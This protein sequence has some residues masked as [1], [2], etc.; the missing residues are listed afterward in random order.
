MFPRQWW[1]VGVRNWSGAG[2]RSVRCLLEKKCQH[3]GGPWLL[4]EFRGV[5][6]CEWTVKPTKGEPEPDAH[7][8]P[9]G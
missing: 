6:G 2:C 3:A 7:V 9:G 1:G 4:L 5:P 8:E